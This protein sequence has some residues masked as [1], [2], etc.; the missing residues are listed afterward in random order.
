MKNSLVFGA[1]SAVSS[2]ALYLIAFLLGYQTTNIANGQWFAVLYFLVPIVVLYFG[3]REAREGRQDKS[4]A[5]PYSQALV[6]A[7]TISCFAGVFFAIYLYVHFAF[8]NTNFVQYYSEFTRNKM[9]A[10]GKMTPDQIDAMVKMQARFM[11]PGAQAIFTL[12]I[13]PIIGTIEG[14]ILAIFVKR[15]APEGQVQS[16]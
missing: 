15:P 13:G 14:L 5:Y 7:V 4:A 11:G 6:S 10:L 3:M 12:V 2:A 16:V 1:I 9:E 8:I